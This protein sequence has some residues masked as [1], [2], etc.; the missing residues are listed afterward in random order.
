MRVT[1]IAEN[2]SRNGA[3]R[4]LDLIA[5]VADAVV[6]QEVVHRQLSRLAESEDEPERQAERTRRE[7]EGGLGTQV[8]HAGDQYHRQGDSKLP[9]ERGAAEASSTHTRPSHRAMTVPASHPQIAC[10]P[11]MTPRI[12][13]M[14]KNGPTPTMFDMFMAMDCNRPKL[15]WSLCGAESEVAEEGFIGAFLGNQVLPVVAAQM[16]EA[17]GKG[18]YA[19]RVEHRHVLAAAL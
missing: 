7:G 13:G 17:L 8:P 6:A 11:P 16:D 14:V 1:I 4:L 15:R 19:Q 9:P 10:G 12:S 18:R 2:G 5:D 3:R